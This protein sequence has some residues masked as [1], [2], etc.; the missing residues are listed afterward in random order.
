[1]PSTSTSDE[2]APIVLDPRAND[3]TARGS[4][5][6]KWVARTTSGERAASCRPTDLR[7]RECGAI[8]EIHAIGG[9]EWLTIL[10][11]RRN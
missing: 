6:K 1:V 2:R 9:H 11:R 8:D 3:P 7:R 4:R 5:T 10:I